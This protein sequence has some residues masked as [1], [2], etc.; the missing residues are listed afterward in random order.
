M[1]QRTNPNQ[2]EKVLAEIR[3]L[4]AL[5]GVRV[6]IKQPKATKPN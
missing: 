3:R 5:I 2:H 4:A 1:N 6:R